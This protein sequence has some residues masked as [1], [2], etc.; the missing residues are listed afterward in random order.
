MDSHGRDHN[1]MD[2]SSSSEPIYIALAFLSKSAV[3][4]TLLLNF[5]A[6]INFFL[7]DSIF[8]FSKILLMFFS[9]RGGVPAIALLIS[10]HIN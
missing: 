7:S 8:S 3:F 6:G 10:F 1:V 5:N 9:F 2:L 4:S